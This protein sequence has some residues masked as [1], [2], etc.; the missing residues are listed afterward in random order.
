MSQ[1]DID[2]DL[3]KRLNVFRKINILVLFVSL[4]FSVSYFRAGLM[5]NATFTFSIWCLFLIIFFLHKFGFI[6]VSRILLITAINTSAFVNG[7][8]LGPQAEIHDIFFGFVLIPLMIF[9][10][11]ERRQIIYSVALSITLRF[12]SLSPI[13]DIFPRFELPGDLELQMP[14]FLSSAVFILIL[15]S[16]YD[17]IRASDRNE[18]NIMLKNKE[19]VAYRLRDEAL[20]NSSLMGILSISRDGTILFAN[21]VAQKELETS[22]RDLIGKNFSEFYRK[23]AS[24][25]LDSIHQNTNYV[26]DHDYFWTGHGN[27][28]P[29]SICVSQISKG[30][31]GEPGTSVVFFQN[32]K[33]RLSLQKKVE[34]ERQRSQHAKKMSVFA[35]TLLDIGH[36]IKNPLTI[37]FNFAELLNQPENR[38]DLNTSLKMIE[39]QSLRVQQILNKMN[40]YFNLNSDE[41]KK[42]P[43]NSLIE[44]G[45]KI[46]RQDHID[47]FRDKKT[48]FYI[49]L[50]LASPSPEVDVNPQ[51][52]I[53]CLSILL[54]NA[55]DAVNEKKQK[56][57]QFSPK[58]QI[59]TDISNDYITLT[60]WDNGIG[61]PEGIRESIF[62]PFFTTKS[63]GTGLGLSFV[64][65]V[66][67]HEFGWK[68]ELNSMANEFTKIEIKLPIKS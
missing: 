68:L 24:D 33:D 52:F 67:E 19:L 46:F 50:N 27:T 40:L 36:E 29:V 7:V 17:F 56:T 43:L 6:Q 59:Q 57:P 65:D 58:I 63:A 16:S 1:G 48:I 54:E 45:L 66:F 49:E 26:C 12:I 28:V 13:R 8:T 51:R 15:K 37:I 10:F 5:F 64:R 44:Y 21:E 61:I 2:Y 42:V 25:F 11:Q 47:R 18:K 30:K 31:D 23:D 9:K 35:N 4:F 22:L 53:R 39:E 34:E 62:Q 3:E 38:P 41:T 55:E 60:V 14:Y 20:L 32:I